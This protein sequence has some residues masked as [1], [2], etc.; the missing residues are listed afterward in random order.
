M[1]RVNLWDAGQGHGKCSRG[2]R[3][4]A[5]DQRR[6]GECRGERGFVANLVQSTIGSRVEMIR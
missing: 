1:R 3:A 4:E 5:D 2:E 6:F